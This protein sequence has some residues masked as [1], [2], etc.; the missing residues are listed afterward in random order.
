MRAFASFFS[1]LSFVFF[2]HRLP[3]HYI[4]S[5]GVALS[6]DLKVILQPLLLY[7]PEILAPFFVRRFEFDGLLLL[8][9]LPILQPST[10]LLLLLLLQHLLLLMLHLLM[11]NHNLTLW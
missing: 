5:I 8:L 6:E 7:S 3:I 2:W 1:F 9:L 11:K 10:F 4:D